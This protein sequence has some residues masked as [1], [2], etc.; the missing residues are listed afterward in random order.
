MGY[1]SF[2]TADPG[3][4]HDLESARTNGA[5]CNCLTWARDPRIPTDSHSCPSAA[6]RARLRPCSQCMGQYVTAIGQGGQPA[7]AQGGGTANPV[8]TAI[9]K[10]HDEICGHVWSVGND[11]VLLQAHVNVQRKR[12]SSRLDEQQRQAKADNLIHMVTGSLLAIASATTAVSVAVDLAHESR[13]GRWWGLAA[14]AA[15]LPSLSL[16]LVTLL[17]AAFWRSTKT[18]IELLDPRR[19]PVTELFH[20]RLKRAISDTCRA[21]KEILHDRLDRAV[22]GAYHLD[23]LVW[24]CFVGG[25]VAALVSTV[26]S[27]KPWVRLWMV[28]PCCVLYL[29]CAVL[30]KVTVD[31]VL[32]GCREQRDA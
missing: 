22:S 9:R 11:I 6:F 30:A 31:G 15:T 14:F 5:G 8:I 24:W 23:G 21:V 7:I 13:L 19:G 4:V 12:I 27:M 3:V 17:V 2:P 32:N 25:G 10:H 20:S 26:T 28:P 1:C 29:A 18:P 16:V